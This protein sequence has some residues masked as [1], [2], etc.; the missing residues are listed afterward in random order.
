MELSGPSF[1]RLLIVA[2]LMVAALGALWR[3]A[4]GLFTWFGRLPGDIRVVRGE[5]TIVVPLTSMIAAS[6]IISV[7]L[8]F[9]VW[10]WRQGA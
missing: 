3:W 1:S 10:L 9:I 6:I 7:I 5:M 8:N 2:G 4:P